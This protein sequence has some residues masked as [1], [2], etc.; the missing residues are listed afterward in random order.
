M[1]FV[2]NGQLSLHYQ[3]L[4]FLEQKPL[5]DSVN[6]Q[7]NILTSVNNFDSIE[8]K[9]AFETRVQ[10]FLCPS[11]RQISVSGNNYR[12]NLGPNPFFLKTKKYRE[13]VGLSKFL[14]QHGCQ[15]FQMD[16]AQQ[17]A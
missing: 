5:Y 8:N 11:D 13:A 16:L 10:I 14:K 6:Y 4:P 12:A 9:T 15:R 3:V 7:L 2:G 1:G 17:S